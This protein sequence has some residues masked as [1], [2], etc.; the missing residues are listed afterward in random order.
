M[1]TNSKHNTTW[2]LAGG[3]RSESGQSLIMAMAI[4][5]L[6][7]FIGG[8]FVTMVSRNIVNTQ[9]SSTN[10]SGDYLAEA[11]VKYADDQLTYSEDGADWRPTP[12]YPEV[13]RALANGQ[14][15][16][17][18][19]QTLN[20]ADL[21]DQRDPDY[22]WLMRGFSRFSY[23]AGRFLLRVS[24]DPTPIDAQNFQ[25]DPMSKYMKIEAIGRMGVVDS[26]DPTTWRKQ[27]E[28]QH[29]SKV[30]YKAIGLTDYARFITNKDRLSDDIPLGSPGFVTRF[31]EFNDI[32]GDGK[33][34]TTK[35]EGVGGPIRVNGDLLWYG[36]DY[37]Y[38]DPNHG[39]RVEVAGD[40]KHSNRSGD[41]PTSVFV[42]TFRARESDDAG[43]DTD[44]DNPVNGTPTQ[45]DMDRLGK[46]RDGRTNADFVGRPRQIQR[47]DP[48]L[49]DAKVPGGGLTRYR[50]LTRNSGEWRQRADS[51]WYNTG[52]YGWGNGIYM[53]NRND[54]QP[55]SEQTTL[56]YEWTHPGTSNWIGPYYAP[57]G[58]I[59]EL[60]DRDLNDDGQPD[61]IIT[62]ENR[63][64]AKFDWFDR[65]GNLEVHDGEK[66]IMPYPR[67][68]VIFAEGN[69][70]IR[71]TLPPPPTANQNY[72]PQITVVSGG[73]IYVEGNI[74]KYQM[75]DKNAYLKAGT[76]RESAIALLA[77]DY[78]CVNTT[79]FFAPV[80][81][82]LMAGSD[83]EH[84][85][86]SPDRS[87]W[88]NF[89]FGLDPTQEYK[90]ANQG[91]APVKLY[92]RHTSTAEYGNAYV[93]MLLNYPPTEA[94]IQNS[95]DPYFSLYSFGGTHTYVLGNPALSQKDPGWE[96][97]VLPLLPRPNEANYRFYTNPGIYNL[98]G[99][100]LDQSG[101]DG[102]GAVNY[103]MSRA[104]VQPCDI[105]IEALLYAQNKS[106]FVIPG[107]WLNPDPN[108]TVIAY[109]RNNN[110]RPL[111]VDP[112]YP[113]YEQPLDVK[114]TVYGAVSEN[115][116]A[117]IA[118]SSEWMR[119]WGWI[120]GRHGSSDVQANP[121]DD[122]SQYRQP[123]RPGQT[124]VDAMM[125]G[126][127]FIYDPQLAYPRYVDTANNNAI[128]Q[129]RTD[130][131]GR[132]LPLVPRL[133]VSPQTLYVGEP[134]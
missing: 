33:L 76:P 44:P 118:D 126:L 56:P 65:D 79:R 77:T 47:L 43:F 124:G 39:E 51:T 129:P 121:E 119:K 49:I 54:L 130:Q 24:Y 36:D 101:N 107:E 96:C 93:N 35:G 28:R 5:F 87:F 83:G 89:A 98:L 7:V 94:D 9:R 13:V 92:V 131:Y 26:T 66:M 50:Q 3:L 105:R 18:I 71:G 38:L 134:T 31:G 122:A 32:N 1:I 21:P 60:T 67:N 34:D 99:F 48:P 11:G 97:K 16:D 80:N 120:P 116:P 25:A 95:N 55:E 109:E 82:V 70:R 58:I 91:N 53:D 68:G 72:S 103:L 102:L 40:I 88:V 62:H 69:I 133:P 110:T 114:V 12:D 75:D 106:F 113:F 123:L 10:M 127:T 86:I 4:M 81:E 22:F 59:I 108:D 14:T 61:M 52:Y 64:G 111:G 125:A 37:V 19:E 85:E 17:Q 45:A 132:V 57:P 117:S 30:A 41:N 2:G 74:L 112:A 78:V 29:S 20:A 104:A 42:N 63:S 90:V 84:F 23:G 27:P 15:P 46:Y 100:Q 6:L 73:T 8:L 128:K 115:I